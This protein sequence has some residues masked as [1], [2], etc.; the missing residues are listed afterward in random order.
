[1]IPKIKE[2]IGRRGKYKISAQQSVKHVPQNAIIATAQ[3]FTEC[4]A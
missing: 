1:M 3:L 2:C 4:N